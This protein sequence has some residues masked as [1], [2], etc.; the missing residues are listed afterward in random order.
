MRIGCDMLNHRPSVTMLARPNSTEP[1]GAF[2]SIGG[3]G[4]PGPVFACVIQN[5]ERSDPLTQ[6]LV[7]VGE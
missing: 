5:T 7:A 2:T 4:T 3:P 1:A 6:K